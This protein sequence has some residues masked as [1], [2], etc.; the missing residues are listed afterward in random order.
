MTSSWMGC[1]W[2]FIL[3]PWRIFEYYWKVFLFTFVSIFFTVIYLVLKKNRFS[4]LKLLHNEFRNS[5]KVCTVTELVYYMSPTTSRSTTIKD[6]R[7]KI[8][9]I[10]VNHET[11]SVICLR[12]F[13][14]CTTWTYRYHTKDGR[15]MNKTW[16]FILKFINNLQIIQ[17]SS[18]TK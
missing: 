18:I 4:K 11:F 15:Q 3:I 5:V 13:L 17:I 9:I 14:Y 7:N 16:V 1:E 12:E 10:Q 2:L 8:L 6:R